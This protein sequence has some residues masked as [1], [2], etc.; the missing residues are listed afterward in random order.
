MKK[1]IKL[2]F[3]IGL[4]LLSGLIISKIIPIFYPEIVHTNSK[5][6]N[7]FEILF[8]VALITLLII[9]YISGKRND[10]HN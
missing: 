7:Y 8:Y 9:S 2:E 5:L 1:R 10:K 4:A 3:P 6:K